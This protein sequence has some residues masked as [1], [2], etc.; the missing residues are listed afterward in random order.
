MAFLDVLG[1]QQM[2]LNGEKEK[3]KLFFNTVDDIFSEYSQ[4]K[5]EMIKFLVS[6]SIILAV[7]CNEEKLRT[8]LRAIRNSQTKLAVQNIW[9]RGAISYGDIT[10]DNGK[11]IIYGEGYLKAFNLESEEAL[12]P[13]VIIDPRLIPKIKDNR[14]EFLKC[15]S[16]KFYNH[17]NVSLELDKIKADVENDFISAGLDSFQEENNDVLFV[18]YSSRLIFNNREKRTGGDLN[19]IIENI[20]SNIYS[21][22]SR[23]KKYNWVK[24]YFAF[25]INRYSNKYFEP[26]NSNKTS[27]CLY[28][29]LKNLEKL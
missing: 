20:K 10:Y 14:E 7:E 15:F 16:S 21:E 25:S 13:R 2:I 22:V 4:I 27:R 9:L 3:I 11:N 29:A 5:P 18:N 1:F 17:T 26:G 28:E 8:L 23:Y 24:N 12:Y 19:K 6:D